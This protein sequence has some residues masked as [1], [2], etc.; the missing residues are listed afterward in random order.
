MAKTNEIPTELQPSA[1][2]YRYDLER[3]LKAD[4]RPAD[5]VDLTGENAEI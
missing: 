4:T 5:E 3:T 2:D 1:R